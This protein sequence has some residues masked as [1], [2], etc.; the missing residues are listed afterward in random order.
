[1]GQHL[2][3][4]AELEALLASVAAQTADPRAGVFGPGS[5]T[6][7]VN[8]EAALFLG[9]GRAALLQLAH[10]WVATALEQHSA[11]LGDPIARFHNTFRIVFTMV[12]GSLGQALA[13]ARHLHTL[14]T[15]IRG[16][17][18]G[19]VAGWSAGTHYEANEVAAL[20]WVYATLVESAV[21][22]YSTVHPFSTEEQ[23][24]YYHESKTMAG[25]FG[26]PT[27][28]LPEDW[29]AFRQYVAQMCRSQE[30]GVGA[31]ARAMAHAILQ[32]A[33]SWV[34]IPGWYRA[35]TAEW[36]G[37]R[38]R[39]EFGLPW[40]AADRRRAARAQRWLPRVWGTLP[41]AVRFVGPWHEAGT[42]LLAQ[43]PGLV[44]LIGNRFWIGQTLLPFANLSSLELRQ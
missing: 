28:E 24:R 43:R 32:G 42:R 16:E 23:A 31:P 17:M 44:T 15:G 3:S 11:L 4:R 6:W 10:P 30:L 1:M 27:A 33:G 35:L 40:S 37:A 2:V 34:R 41:S 14:H 13:A 22:A 12:F 25:L 8:R 21:V 5:M 36:L 7:K 29:P 18:P 26:L 38:F 9:A 20:R 39:E 19:K